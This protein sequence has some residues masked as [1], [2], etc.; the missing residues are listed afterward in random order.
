MKQKVLKGFVWVFLLT[1]ATPLFAAGDGGDHGFDL[2]YFIAKTVNFCIFF[3]LL[4]FLLRKPISNFFSTRLETIQENLR[5]A[6]K[7]REEAKRQLDEI[8]AKMAELDKEIN[9]IEVNAK[10]EAE[11]ERA[12]I[13]EEAQKE[14]ERIVEQARLD[15]AT[16]KRQAV[17]DLKTYV[18]NLAMDEA[19][20]II[21]K[22]IN[23]T[24]QKRIFKEFSQKLEANV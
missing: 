12:R 4:Y 5:L 23:E 6:E 21:R 16:M 24:D 13:Q 9:E 14:A 22:T 17:D 3:G 7:S 10:A 20:A 15:V 2:M 8:Q 18:S 19:E 11:R 1:L